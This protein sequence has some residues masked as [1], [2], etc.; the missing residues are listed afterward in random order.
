M[1]F[2][3]EEI[4]TLRSSWAKCRDKPLFGKLLFEYIFVN[5]PAALPMF[6]FYDPEHGMDM[7]E[8]MFECRSFKKH[9]AGVVK[10][11]SAVVDGLDDLSGVVKILTELG[12]RHFK[13]GI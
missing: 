9:C 11:I 1:S 5:E 10:A 13:I 7:N 3:A 2:T 12:D 6:P 8:K 4:S